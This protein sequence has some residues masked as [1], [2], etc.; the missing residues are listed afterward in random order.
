VALASQPIPLSP[1]RT[2]RLPALLEWWH[3]LSL[4]A[5]CVAALWAW[6]FA[7]AL[8]LDLPADSLLL[9]FAG[10]WLLYIADRV[11]DGFHQSPAR[12]RERHFFCMRHRVA[13]LLTAVP[14]AVLLAW[15][16]FAHMLPAA[17]SADTL[18][19]SV[20]CAYFCLV[21]LPRRALRHAVERW[22]PKELIV[23]LVFASATAVPAFARI[24]GTVSGATLRSPQT[25]A[26]LPALAVLFA[27]LC[28]LNCI[29]I[30]KWEQ[31]PPPAGPAQ[32]GQSRTAPETNDLT[33]RWGQR[34]LR[35]ISASIAS[36]AVLAAAL[37]LHSSPAAAGLCFAAAIAAALFI[38]LEHSTLSVPHLRIAADAVLLTPLL[39]FL[40]R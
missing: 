33:T 21:H 9:L 39:L 31:A 15:L 20:A 26:V 24:T 18:I 36:V 35:L 16:V 40:L 22:L 14:I 17:R 34:H 3:L 13:I 19:F 5:P 4:D 2:A 10:T 12:L 8:H 28:W 1:H 25:Q 11:L 38:A 29:A 6:G 30:E 32:S 37:L 27:A 7:G 23:A